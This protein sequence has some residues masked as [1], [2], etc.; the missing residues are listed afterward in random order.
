MEVD[1]EYGEPAPPFP[2]TFESVAALKIISAAMEPYAPLRQRVDSLTGTPLPGLTRIM[3]EKLASWCVRGSAATASKWEEKCAF[4]VRAEAIRRFAHKHSHATSGDIEPKLPPDPGA[5]R[6][7]EVFWSD[8]L[9][10]A[11]YTGGYISAVCGDL[12]CDALFAALDGLSPGPSHWPL[13]PRR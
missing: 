13:H 1:D 3:E 4:F 10:P 12:L 8:Y 9:P 11:E 7:P 2:W 6:E 5:E